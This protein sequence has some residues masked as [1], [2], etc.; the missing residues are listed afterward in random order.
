MPAA[1]LLCTRVLWLRSNVM[2]LGPLVPRSNDPR[3]NDPSRELQ[4][5]EP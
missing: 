1:A 2:S 3:S 4:P 5:G